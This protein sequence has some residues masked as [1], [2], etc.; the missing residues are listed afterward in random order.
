[1]RLTVGEK[2]CEGVCVFVC[3]CVGVLGSSIPCSPREKRC[4]HSINERG[5][6]TGLLAGKEKDVGKGRTGGRMGHS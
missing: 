6:E 2:D 4:N 5:R 1:M 3:L